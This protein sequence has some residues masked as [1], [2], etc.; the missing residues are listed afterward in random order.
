MDHDQSR[1]RPITRVILLIL[2]Y[3]SDHLILLQE[4]F[5]ASLCPYKLSFLLN[6]IYKVFVLSDLYLPFIIHLWL[7]ICSQFLVLGIIIFIIIT[8]VN[9][10]SILCHQVTKHLNYMI[11]FTPQNRITETKKTARSQSWNSVETEFKL[12]PSILTPITMLYCY[13]EL[14]SDVQ[15]GHALLHTHRPSRTLFCL[16]GRPQCYHSPSPMTTC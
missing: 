11:S 7:L 14:L 10:V 3:Q 16:D 2:K 13:S 8:K 5:G 12:R 6:M 9:T 4:S 15:M 1:L